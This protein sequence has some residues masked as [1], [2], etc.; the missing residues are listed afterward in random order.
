MWKPGDLAMFEEANGTFS[1]V[2]IL[3]QE[4]LCAGETVDIYEPWFTV[5][6]HY[7]TLL[8]GVAPAELAPL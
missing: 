5:M 4:E 1:P 2:I 3:E 7:G 6:T 8:W